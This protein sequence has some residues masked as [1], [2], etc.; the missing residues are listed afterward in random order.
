M[1]AMPH[2]FV[3]FLKQRGEPRACTKGI[4]TPPFMDPVISH[5]SCPFRTQTHFLS[6][7][8]APLDDNGGRKSNNELLD[9]NG[10]GLH[11]YSDANNKLLFNNFYM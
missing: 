7:A 11:C 3:T 1:G 10:N 9:G 8:N 4:R 2:L 6:V 5:P